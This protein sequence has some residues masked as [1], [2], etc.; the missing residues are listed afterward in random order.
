MNGIFGLNYISSVCNEFFFNIS[1]C[2]TS[3]IYLTDK[4]TPREQK[5]DAFVIRRNIYLCFFIYRSMQFAFE[6]LFPRD[7][8]KNTRFAINFFTS[9]GLGGLTWVDIIMLLLWFISNTHTIALFY[10]HSSKVKPLL[11]EDYTKNSW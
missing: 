11:K 2:W 5:Y 10:I 1:H 8:P 6:G 3:C 4:I 7:N 9:I